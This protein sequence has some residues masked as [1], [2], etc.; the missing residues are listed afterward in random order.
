MHWA[1]VPMLYKTPLGLSSVANARPQLSMASTWV[2][3]L[4]IGNLE[5]LLV[6]APNTVSHA[7]S[8]VMAG[9]TAG[10]KD[11]VPEVDLAQLVVR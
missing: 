5:A 1:R 9:M 10:T 7:G 8:S 6:R 3:G 11:A 2:R 4:C